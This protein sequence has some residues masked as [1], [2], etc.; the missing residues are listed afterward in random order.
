[1]TGTDEG[2]EVGAAERA[3]LARLLPPA[4][5][6]ALPPGRHEHHR[7]RL[8]KLIDDDTARA[9]EH[10]GARPGPE[11]RA[12]GRGGHPARPRLLRPSFLAPV[13]ALA[14]A[15]VLVAG[16][17]ARDGGPGAT[18]DTRSVSQVLHRISDA[19][20]RNEALPV[21]DDQFVYT[22]ATG[23]EV[24]LTSGTAVVGPL[25]ESEY[26]FSQR[27]GP[28][29]KLGLSR[30]DGK[31]MPVNAELGDSEGTR[32][33]LSRPTYRWLATLPTEPRQLLDYLTELTPKFA[34]EDRDHA[35]FTSIGHL[36]GEPLL[37]P[38]T[39]SALFEAVAL[40]PGVTRAPD[41]V[42]A[43]GRKGV[44]IA[45]ED[46]RSATRTEWVFDPDDL[47]YLGWSSRLTRDTEYGEKG[48]L[49]GDGA[50]IE[51]AV[52]DTA[53]VPPRD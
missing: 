23:R 37:P 44:G 45:R 48:G 6:T 52:V 28:Q 38:D 49:L 53:G 18:G 31:T 26:W 15:G 35:V 7:E 34:G 25:K 51:R 30:T 50:V 21:R 29:K 10:A 36:I 9:Q 16:Y 8:M 22:R 46:D 17:S 32:P 42:D 3:G 13:T 5:V 12:G 39:A 2:R 47:T 43:L 14:L 1:M 24:D 11:D 4:P 33:G 27:P 20:G 40:I 41:A 19:A